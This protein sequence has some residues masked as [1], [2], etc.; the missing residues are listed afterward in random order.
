[1]WKK[2]GKTMEKLEENVEKIGKTMEKLEENGEKLEKTMEKHWK[3]I[4]EILSAMEVEW[5][6]TDLKN[7]GDLM[8]SSSS[9][10]SFNPG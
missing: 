2:L 10:W 3:K 9:N 8:G 4:W 1:M 5:I 6:L 7:D